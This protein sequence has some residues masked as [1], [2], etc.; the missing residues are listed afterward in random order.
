MFRRLAN[1]FQGSEHVSGQS[2]IGGVPITLFQ[3]RKKKRSLNDN[4]QSDASRC[5][6]FDDC[7]DFVGWSQHGA[8]LAHCYRQAMT[9][10]YPFRNTIE[11]E[12]VLREHHFAQLVQKKN[13]VKL[14]RRFWRVGRPRTGRRRAACGGRVRRRCSR[15]TKC[16][17]AWRTTSSAA[18]RAIGTTGSPPGTKRWVG[19]MV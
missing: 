3:K 2:S 12:M 15:T 7:V 18:P 9:G 13:S 14:T 17:P 5:V 8:A 4:D 10:H 19:R 16:P 1:V 6:C 11:P